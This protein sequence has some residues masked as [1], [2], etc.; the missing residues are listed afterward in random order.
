[1]VIACVAGVVPS[2]IIVYGIAVV[3]IPYRILCIVPI[4]GLPTC[5]RNKDDTIESIGTD[6]VN[7]WL[8]IVAH[9]RCT[10][11]SVAV[12]DMYWLVGKLKH[13]HARIL[14]YVCIA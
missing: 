11:L 12:I 13:H 4:V 9:S 1:M 3:I 7:D 8:E 5:S 2:R 10:C 14:L 6:N